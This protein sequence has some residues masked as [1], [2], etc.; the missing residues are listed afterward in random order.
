MDK[1]FDH[2][3]RYIERDGRKPVFTI[4]YNIVGVWEECKSVEKKKRRDSRTV[5]T[6]RTMIL[7]L[8]GFCL[9]RYY[10]GACPVQRA[11]SSTSY[12][13]CCISTGTTNCSIPDGNSIGAS[14]FR[15]TSPSRIIA[16]RVSGSC[17][18][19]SKRPN[20]AT[21]FSCLLRQISYASNTAPT[22]ICLFVVFHLLKFHLP[23]ILIFFRE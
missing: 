18:V 6:R 10:S 11:T 22:V 5:S 13:N 21:F 9:Y 7:R 2:L 1:K 20:L 16:G 12:F 17:T 14:Q 3:F 19:F 23:T 4:L 15:S 8:S